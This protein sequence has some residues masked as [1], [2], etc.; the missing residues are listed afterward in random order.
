MSSIFRLR[1]LA[2]TLA[3]LLTAALPGAALAERTLESGVYSADQA[4][5]GA[6][7]F[8]ANCA[9]C[10]EPGYFR[11]VF[12]AWRGETLASLFDVM[13]GT[14]PQSSPGSLRDAEYV[15]VL[16]YILS[17]TGYPAGDAP[18]DI[19]AGDLDEITIVGP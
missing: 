16:T 9:T 1:P 11:N 10:H 12:P 3:C 19:D 6:K 17:A 7:L 14:M 5:A 2:R 8:Q 13:A 4:I 18:L 15:D